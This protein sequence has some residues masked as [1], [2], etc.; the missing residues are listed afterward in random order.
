[1]M[2]DK[3]PYFETQADTRVILFIFQGKTPEPN[4][5]PK[6]WPHGLL[7]LV[8]KCWSHEPEDR[9]DACTCVASLNNVPKVVSRYPR[10]QGVL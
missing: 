3:G 5:P 4:P 8:R 9:P 10:D 6:D 7:E 1:M 2:T